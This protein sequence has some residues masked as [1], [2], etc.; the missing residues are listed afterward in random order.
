ML[1]AILRALKPG[2]LLGIIDAPAKSG[3]PRE[4]YFERHRIPDQFVR[5]DAARCGFTFVR[6]EPGFNPP[7]NDRNYFF[8]IFQKPENRRGR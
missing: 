1:G 6:Q 2:G 5:D 7:D 4:K 8:L 3:E